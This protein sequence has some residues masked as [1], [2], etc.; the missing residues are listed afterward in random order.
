MK[1][2]FALQFS[3][4]FVRLNPNTLLFLLLYYNS[5]VWLSSLSAV[6]WADMDSTT[7]SLCWMDDNF[8]TDVHISKQKDPGEAH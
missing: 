1:L 5:Q 3:S 8:D 2:Q 4:I 6:V 7:C